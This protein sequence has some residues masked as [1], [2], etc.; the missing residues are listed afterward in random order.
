MKK[1][2]DLTEA[3]ILALAISSE[4]EDSRIYADFAHKTRENFPATA[5]MFDEMTEEEQMHKNMLISTYRLRFGDK[6]PYITRADVKGFMK[7]KSL[8]LMD[9]V[10]IDA[11][12]RQAE[13][14]EMEAVAF[15]T[16]AAEQATDIDVRKLLGDLAI[17][18]RGHKAKAESLQASELQGGAIAEEER[19]AKRLFLLQIV[20]PA[21]TG[22]I[23]GSISTLAPIFAAAFATHQSWD[24]FV[25][26]MAASIGA[27]I[28]M[29][30]TEA[31]SDD[32]AIT[33]RGN[34]WV[35]GGL[36]GLMTTVGGLGHTLPYLIPD[37]W[38][39]TFVAFVVVA[40]ELLAIAWIRWKYM[41]LPFTSA[42]TQIVLGGILV[43]AVGILIGGA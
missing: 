20:Q 29:G 28:S 31:V 19:E 6:I 35:R 3:E 40:I 8:W 26:G 25:V 43:V 33:G 41:D 10:R 16:K 23:D 12:R 21:L 5:A 27:G 38:T 36:C 11:I 42:M 39:A 18:E 30:I 37:F 9:N 4:E 17:I 13:L 32:G 22:L 15:Y 1:L 7:R 14:M 34:P 2:Q 24:A